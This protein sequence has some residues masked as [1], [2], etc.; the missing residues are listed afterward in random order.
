MHK[1]LRLFLYPMHNGIKKTFLYFKK[2]QKVLTKT[3]PHIRMFPN[4][5]HIV[6]MKIEITEVS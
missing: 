3:I 6:K 2:T 1:Y 5:I 4:Q